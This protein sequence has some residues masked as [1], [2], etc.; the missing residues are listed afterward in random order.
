MN[1]VL[2]PKLGL[3]ISTSTRRYQSYFKNEYLRV[4]G[5]KLDKDAI[6]ITVK[7]VKRLPQP[8]DADRSRSVSFKKTLSCEYLIRGLETDNVTIYFK[9]NIAGKL[10]TKLVTLFLQAQVL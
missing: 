10:Y 4:S 6:T 5:G 7:I 9:D 1:Y 2:H 3:T 8:R